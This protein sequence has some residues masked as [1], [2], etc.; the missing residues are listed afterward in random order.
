MFLQHNHV[1][2]GKFNI[3]GLFIV[4]LTSKKDA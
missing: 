1:F 3:K 4:N 2:N